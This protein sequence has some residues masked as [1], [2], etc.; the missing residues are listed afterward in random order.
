MNR[1]AELRI[2]GPAIS[3]PHKSLNS[4]SFSLTNECHANRQ[5]KQI[6]IVFMV[7]HSYICRLF[8]RGS[9]FLR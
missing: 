9:S 6:C 2:S 8:M 7:K 4:K 5:S 3:L 1:L